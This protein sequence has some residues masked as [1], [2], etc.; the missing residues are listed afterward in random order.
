MFERLLSILANFAT[1]IALMFELWHFYR[2]R[3]SDDIRADDVA[4]YEEGR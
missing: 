4:E 3:R 2:K 1:V